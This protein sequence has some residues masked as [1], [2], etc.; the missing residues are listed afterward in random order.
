MLPK[1]NLVIAALVAIAPFALSVSAD[2]KPNG[3]QNIN[4]PKFFPKPYPHPYPFPK[5][6]K[7]HWHPN[8]KPVIVVQQ[9]VYQPIVR[10]VV[11]HVTRPIT[12]A[13]PKMSCLT[14]EYTPEG[15]LIFKDLCTKETAST[16]IPGTPA[17]AAAMQQMQQQLQQMQQGAAQGTAPQGNGPVSEVPKPNNFAGKS[18]EEF[19]ANQ[20]NA[21]TKAPNIVATDGAA[22][23]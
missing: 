7:P 4:G 2:A 6:H 16:P 8:F 13:A 1:S 19:K 9:P 23:D 12:V 10:P 22:K 3:P 20:T 14:K 15:M 17:A 18:Y 21:Q 11:Q 5:P